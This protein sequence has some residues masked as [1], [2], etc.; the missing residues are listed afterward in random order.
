M[1][2]IKNLN[3]YY[4]KNKPNEIHVINNTNLEIESPGLVTFL[5]S[6]GA[7]KSTLLHVIGGLDKARGDVIYDNI[8]INKSRSS[9]IDSYRNKHIGYIFQNYNLLPNLTVYENL[10][11]QLELINIHDK[12]TIDRKINE[13]LKIVGLEKYKRRKITALS[14]G[15]QQRVSI[16]RALVKGAE[17]IIADEPTG[18]LDSKNSIEI[19]NILKVLSKKYLIILVTHDINLAMHYSDRVIK[20]KDG[21]IIEDIV[22]KNNN[23]LLHIDSNALYLNN[24]QKNS[25]TEANNKVEIYS[26]NNEK[27]NFRIVI[28]ND[29]IYIENNNNLPIRVLNENTDRYIIEETP[30]ED[31]IDENTILNLDYIQAEKPKMKDVFIN[32]FRDIKKSFTNIFNGS[33]KTKLLYISFFV[34]GVILCFCLN[35]LSISTT[36]SNNLLDETPKGA[37]RVD[38][39]NATEDSKY[40]ITFNNE[41]LLEILQDN[42]KINGAVDYIENC[43]LRFKVIANRTTAINLSKKCFITTPKTY[44]GDDTVLKNN[45]I[46]ISN[47]IANQI[48]A[49]TKSYNINTYEELIDKEF[50]VNLTGYY[51]GDMVIKDVIETYDYTFLVSDYVYFS[52]SKGSYTYA[53]YDL[54]YLWDQNNTY[55]DYY[56]PIEIPKGDI[57]SYDYKVPD[58]LISKN[59]VNNFIRIDRFLSTHEQTVWE[60]ASDLFNV[61]GAIDE[62]GFNIVFRTQADYEKFIDSSMVASNSFLP[63]R[64]Y[65]INLVEGRL[66]V[67]DNEV[68]LPNTSKYLNSYPIGSTYS[69]YSDKFKLE[70]VGYFELNFPKNLSQIYTNYNTAYQIKSLD[71]FQKLLSKSPK[72]IY[73]YTD[74]T[75]ELSTYFGEI[76]YTAADA[77]EEVLQQNIIAKMN[78]SKVAIIVSLSIIVVMILFIFFINR[79]KMLQNIYEL[80]VLRALG[81]KKTRLYKQYAIDSIIVSTFTVVLGFSLMYIFTKN[82]NNF[83]PG[84]AVDF[85][86]FLLSI[87]GIY[88]IMISASLLPIYLLLRKT[89]IE[90]INKYD[91]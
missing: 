8:N 9:V 20:I 11:I 25:I 65:D 74:D 29:A 78:A 19:L 16:A 64:S 36:L 59:L 38:L 73:L 21:M 50:Y 6:S 51:Q 80:G 69:Y 39:K 71:I 54:N 42:N 41:E 2:K 91:I 10:K 14:G 44:N 5:G 58:V 48:L 86:W 82:A 57:L 31:I 35:S 24:Y 61:V 85:K 17:V 60:T 12:E 87:L 67:N 15:Q 28:E 53:S 62:E 56:L 7:G 70:V 76:G 77:E 4:N 81:A 3:K 72:E 22:N 66:P 46:I 52:N 13:C 79:S 47:S 83:V 49:Y 26:K 34:I 30:K 32:L 18:N 84:I 89:P 45:E 63:Y 90:I 23:S 40:G 37:I 55:F 88:V 1:I 33:I 75:E 43:Y 68:I 27:L